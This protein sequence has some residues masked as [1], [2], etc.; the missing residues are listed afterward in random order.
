M[1]C[2]PDQLSFQPLLLIFHPPPLLYDSILMS[3]L[4]LSRL[5]LPLHFPANFLGLLFL[6]HL[7][8]FLICLELHICY[9]LL[10]QSRLILVLRRPLPLLELLLSYSSFLHPQ[11]VLSTQCLL[12]SVLDPLDVFQLCQPRDLLKPHA[13]LK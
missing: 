5:E 11:P 10:L 12:K 8:Q 2:L 6:Q 1:H 7:K 9:A 3:L 13:F 4:S